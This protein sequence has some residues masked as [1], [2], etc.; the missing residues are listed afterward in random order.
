EVHRV[1][2]ASLELIGRREG[3]GVDENVEAVPTRRE[4]VEERVDL[5]VVGDVERQHDIALELRG[6]PADAVCELLRLIAER[7]LGAFATHRLCDTPRDRSVARDAD[8]HG[9]PAGEKTHACP[10][11]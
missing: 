6:E 2:V 1:D 4:T 10:L 11:L 3:D 9:P 7:E 8:D 5:A